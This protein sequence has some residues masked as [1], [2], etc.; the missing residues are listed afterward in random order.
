M[1]QPKKLGKYEIV[2]T[3]GK[4]GMGTV[5]R[6]FDPVIQR[7]VALKTIRSD[8]RDADLSPDFIARF[9]NEA[10]AAGRL[11]H[12]G[13]VAVYDY[14]EDEGAAYIAMEFVEGSGL[15]EYF[16]QRI[17]VPLPD[18]VSIMVQLLDALDYAHKQGVV[19]RDIKPANI[20]LT[21]I[22]K[23]KIADFGIARIDT[24]NLTQQG[25]VLGTPNYMSPEQ[26]KGLGAD[27]RSDIFSAG[28]VF[29]ELLTGEKPFQGPLEAMAYKVCNEVHPAP[30][31]RNS[32]VPTVFDTVLTTVLSKHPDQRYQTACAFSLAIQREFEH[33]FNALPA[34]VV[35]EETVRVSALAS[36]AAAIG[37][38]SSSNSGSQ[39]ASLDT[40]QWRDDTLKTVERQLAQYMGPLA[41]VMVKKA[42]ERTGDLGEL[43]TLLATNLDSDQAKNAFLSGR[44]RLSAVHTQPPVAPTVRN[45]HMDPSI[46]STAGLPMLASEEIETGARRLAK[47]VGPIASVLARKAAQKAPDLNTFYNLLADHVPPEARA[48]FLREAGQNQR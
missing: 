16:H 45:L 48:A 20:M 25:S 23:L 19:H 28:V 18:A 47:H 37:V 33:A 44:Q 38:A 35:S 9:K 5:Y 22:G 8:L 15:R 43:Y 4:G 34:A 11:N 27:C 17:K 14:G 7:T 32:A 41:R 10:R 13:I 26:F 24:S 3:L 31:S 40:S 30:S 1:V 36:P 6:A 2:G 21:T 39:G 46:P 12:P 42:A 29:Y